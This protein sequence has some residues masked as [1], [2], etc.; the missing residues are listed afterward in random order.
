MRHPSRTQLRNNIRRFIENFNQHPQIEAA[1]EVQLVRDFMTTLH[2]MF[3]E[4]V[5]AP[6]SASASDKDRDKECL[7]RYITSKIYDRCVFVNGVAT[8]GHIVM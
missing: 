2:F 8:I 5:W 3:T 1:E 4:L 7:E 6:A